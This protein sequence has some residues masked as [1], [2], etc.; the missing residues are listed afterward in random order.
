MASTIEEQFSEALSASGWK[1]R[2][3]LKVFS[4]RWPNCRA[5]TEEATDNVKTVRWHRA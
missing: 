5:G 3:I 2:A 4:N 1:E